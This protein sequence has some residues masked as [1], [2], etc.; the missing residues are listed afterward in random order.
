MWGQWN[1]TSAPTETEKEAYR[2]AGTSFKK[3]LNELRHV[4]EKDLTSLEKKLEFAWYDLA[5]IGELDLRPASIRAWLVA[6][7]R[8]GGTAGAPAFVTT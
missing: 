2:I 3:V 8:T 5:V 7:G 6:G 4:I 1:V